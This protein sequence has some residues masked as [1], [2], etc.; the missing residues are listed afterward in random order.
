MDEIGQTGR[1]SPDILLWVPMND[2]ISGFVAG[3]SS[4]IYYG[5][6]MNDVV[7]KVLHKRRIPIL[8]PE[9]LGANQNKPEQVDSLIYH[10]L[11]AH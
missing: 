6:V 1:W 5:L 11:L 7:E 10:Y 3:K 8:I 2:L 9:S 4:G